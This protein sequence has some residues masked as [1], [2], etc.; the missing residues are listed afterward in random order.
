MK[1]FE[2]LTDD[3]SGIAKRRELTSTFVIQPRQWQQAVA[4]GVSPRSSVP[5]CPEA[6]T[7]AKGL[8]RDFCCRPRRGSGFLCNSFRGLTPTATSCR[9]SGAEKAT[10]SHRHDPDRLKDELFQALEGSTR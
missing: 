10:S 1:H 2:I 9:P 4:V 5:T 3:P 6:P 8:C 7:G